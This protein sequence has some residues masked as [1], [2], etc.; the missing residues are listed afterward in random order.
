[1][2]KPLV[3]IRC[4]TYNHEPYIRQCLEGFV[5]QKTNFRFE[6][7][8]HDDASTDGTVAI[9]REYAEKYPN[10]IKPIYET[11]NQYSKRNGSLT[12][13]MNEHTHGKY[14]AMCEG[15][16]YWIDPL[17]L[18][19]QVDYLEAHQNCRYVFTARY[20]NNEVHG[21]KV[22]QRYK[23]R[24]YKTYDIL[25]G[26][27]PGI[28]NVMFYT[29]DTEEYLKYKGINGDRLFP[30]IASLKGEIH[31]IND[32][33]SVYRVTGKGVSTS[34]EKNK[35]FEHASKDFYMF[36]YYLK[37]PSKKAYLKGLTKYIVPFVKKK[38]YT[39]ILNQLYL[40][41]IIIKKN[42]PN[43]NILDMYMLIIYIIKNKISKILWGSDII[44][45]KIQ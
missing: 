27:N 39:H 11:E 6:A 29:A 13:I 42:N 30:Y 24:V 21:T 38:G 20:V 25:L 37:F 32:I 45:K 28:Q 44:S 4:I 18:Q 8:V 34:I 1:M 10:I 35:W 12:K 17:K 40:S 26:F 22:E 15:D 7:I 5:M 31:Y 2:D 19:K 33:T 3:T 41:Y 36:H 14:V 43:F 16:D 9:I 23:K